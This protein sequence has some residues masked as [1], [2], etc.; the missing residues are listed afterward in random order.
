LNNFLSSHNGRIKHQHDE[1]LHGDQKGK[2][3][4]P[5]QQQG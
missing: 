4:D 5:I 1:C 3:I 2:Y